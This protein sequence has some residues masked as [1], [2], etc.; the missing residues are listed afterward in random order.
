VREFD[1]KNL[2][3]EC[4]GGDQTK[5]GTENRGLL[6]DFSPADARLFERCRNAYL[7]F[8]ERIEPVKIAKPTLEANLQKKLINGIESSVYQRIRDENAAFMK[9]KIFF[10]QEYFSFARDYINLYNFE[11][12]LFFDQEHSSTFKNK[13]LI[14]L[15]EEYIMKSGKSQGEDGNTIRSKFLAEQQLI[16]RQAKLSEDYDIFSIGSGKVGGLEIKIKSDPGLHAIKLAT[17]L[18]Q[19]IITKVKDVQSF[20]QWMQLMDSLFERH[21]LACVWL[22]KHLTENV[23]TF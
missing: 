5:N 12:V 1:A 17:I 20:V 22:I 23:K 10:D 4:F 6:D 2:G 7:L 16:E 8:Y 21:A 11:N 18:S 3:V 13:Q 9:L 19:D 15:T 14:S